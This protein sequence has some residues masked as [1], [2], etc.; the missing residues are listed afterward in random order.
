[1]LLLAASAAT[2]S[3]SRDPILGAVNATRAFSW[4]APMELIAASSA[5]LSSRI[6]IQAKRF[7]SIRI[8]SNNS[9]ALTASSSQPAVLNLLC[10]IHEHL[11]GGHPSVP[12]QSSDCLRQASDLPM[13]H[14]LLRG[15]S[16][17][18][19]LNHPYFCQHATALPHLH[20]LQRVPAR[21]ILQN[22]QKFVRN[23]PR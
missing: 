5:R 22:H 14:L 17:N 7:V 19:Q 20:N 6:A 8:C 15:S 3:S 16:S 13:R 2:P 23:H 1:M 12:R 4:S 18:W 9:T 11:R 21:P 10:R